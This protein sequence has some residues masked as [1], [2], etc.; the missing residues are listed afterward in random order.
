M[1]PYFNI[2]LK[3]TIDDNVIITV[4]ESINIQSS[5]ENITDKATV[6]LPRE[7][8]NAVIKDTSKGNTL[9][10]MP[11]LNFMKVGSKIKIEAGYDDIY[12]TEFLGYITKVCA[13]I[14][15]VIECEDESWILK[16]TEK[17]NK[18]FS[19]TTIRE[20]LR[21]IAPNYSIET[22]S[23][24]RP[25]GKIS[26]EN[27]TA[28]EVLMQLKE[29]YFVRSFFRDGV[30]CA[31]LPYNLKHYKTHQFNLNRNVRKGSDLSYET[32]EDRKFW[33]KAISKQKGTSKEITYE[34][35][36]KGGDVKNITCPLNLS[37]DELK[38][39]AE[40]WYNSFTY[41]GYS[42]SFS[43]WAIPQTRAGDSADLKDPNYIDGHRD[44]VF[45]IT[46]VTVDINGSD[47][48]KRTNKISKKL[49]GNNF[50]PTL[51]K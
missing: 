44:G 5:T 24:E 13:N 32:K 47:G 28:Y 38:K 29:K 7:Y 26:I 45:Y 20:V 2:C 50:D 33:I 1:I 3:V 11:I 51:E 31:G 27:S 25:I 48:F 43:S 4:V 46:E 21:F 14:P 41:D 16:K 17:F 40:D 34:F 49:S 9:A 15:L 12:Q 18:T 19:N 22:F 23:E 39:Y 30:L 42:G 35:G 36:D 10:G 6:T 37:K 8:K